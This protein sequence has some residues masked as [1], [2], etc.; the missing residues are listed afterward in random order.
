MADQILRLERVCKSYN[1]GL[2]TE[3]EVLHDIDLELDH[4]EFLAL[5][6]PSGSGKSTLLNIVGLLDRP[7][8]GRLL[9]KSQDT[10]ALDDAEITRLRGRTIG[11]VFQYHL[12][13]SAFTARENVMMPML[14]DRGF[15]S[16]DVEARANQLLAQVGLE[17]LAGNLANNMSGGQQQRVAVARALAMNPDLVLA[18][19][20]T[21]NLDTSSAEAVFRL[22]RQVNRDSGTSFLLVT[23]NM[24]LA[25]RCDRII[26]VIDG[27]IRA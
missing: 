20:P 15:P 1:V 21:G 11:F 12:L 3:T 23:H 17:K 6:G 18:D 10:A 5:I 2:P 9:I 27:R 16:A 22:M 14:V 4:G 24:D 7:T 26:E 13:I 19:E 8:S 25:R